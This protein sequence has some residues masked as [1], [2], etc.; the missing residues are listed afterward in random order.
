MV[1]VEKIDEVQA[2]VQFHLHCP[3]HCYFENIYFDVLMMVVVVVI[4][5]I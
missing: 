5:L 2:Y 4:Q 3:I 1:H